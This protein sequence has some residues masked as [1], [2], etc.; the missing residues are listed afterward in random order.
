MA[1]LAYALT[2][3]QSV[4]V[5]DLSLDNQTPK[6]VVARVLGANV[7]DARL[8]V[9]RGHGRFLSM[10]KLRALLAEFTPVGLQKVG[11]LPIIAKSVA[12]FRPQD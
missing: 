1:H 2:Q 9:G 3:D 5:A 10:G 4:P 7:F 11:R 8:L 12:V 6:G